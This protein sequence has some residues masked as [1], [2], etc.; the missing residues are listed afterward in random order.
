M[1]SWLDQ[2]LAALNGRATPVEPQKVY[3]GGMVKEVKELQIT[4][5]LIPDGVVGYRTIMYLN[6][7]T[8]GNEPYLN[9]IKGEN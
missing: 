6:S 1:A 5:G 4:A 7:V 9:K 8:G 3:S 2:K